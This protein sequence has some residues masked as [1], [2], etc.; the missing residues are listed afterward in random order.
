MS[1]FQ[2][3]PDMPMYT[4]VIVTSQKEMG[5]DCLR[6]LAL[7][8]GLQCCCLVGPASPRHLPYGV[9][10]PHSSFLSMT[11][12]VQQRHPPLPW[13]SIHTATIPLLPAVLSDT[14]PSVDTPL[15][16]QLVV[17]KR[18]F[19]F[20]GSKNQFESEP[21]SFLSVA[22]SLCSHPV[23]KPY[24][25]LMDSIR[26]AGAACSYEF[27]KSYLISAIASCLLK[28]GSNIAPLFVFVNVCLQTTT[29]IGYRSDFNYQK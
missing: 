6:F 27:G 23:A 7:C 4:H 26:R 8:G 15:P 14:D 12:S 9:L 1:S 2:S 24:S 18:F 25:L 16:S 20:F 5:M 29:F 22:S 21:L 13:S 17:K 11:Y 3:L 28:S 10:T 19:F